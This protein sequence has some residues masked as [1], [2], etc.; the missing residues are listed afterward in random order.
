M[1][2]IC[3]ISFRFL[4]KLR[5]ESQAYSNWSNVPSPLIKVI[6]EDNFRK[7][8]NVFQVSIVC[9][10]IDSACFQTVSSIFNVVNFE[11]SRRLGLEFKIAFEVN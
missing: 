1:M 4:R 6:I 5:Q 10:N 11:V 3:K 9:E 8:K 2:P 7:H